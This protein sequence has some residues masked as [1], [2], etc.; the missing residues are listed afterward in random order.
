MNLQRA[1]YLKSLSNVQTPDVSRVIIAVH[2]PGG[3][4]GKQN[5]F[6]KS[7]FSHLSKTPWQH[8]EL[9]FTDPIPH[10][11]GH[12]GDMEIQVQESG[13]FP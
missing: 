9:D 3:S 6:L 8:L 5:C 4:W 11:L 12:R 2:W 13:M 7:C 1:A 10:Q